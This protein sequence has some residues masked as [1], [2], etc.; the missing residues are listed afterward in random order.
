MVDLQGLLRKALLLLKLCGGFVSD[1]VSAASGSGTHQRKTSGSTSVSHRC[2]L[3]QPLLRT[4]RAHLPYQGVFVHLLSRARSEPLFASPAP[5]A[6]PG[7]ARGLTT[8]KSGACPRDI[9]PAKAPGSCGPDGRAFARKLTPGQ[10]ASASALPQSIRSLLGRTHRPMPVAGKLPEHSPA[11]SPGRRIVPRGLAMRH[12]M[13]LAHQPATRLDAPHRPELHTC[14]TLVRPWAHAGAPLS[15]TRQKK[16]N[17][18]R[19]TTSSTTSRTTMSIKP[20]VFL[21]P[22]LAGERC[23]SIRCVEVFHG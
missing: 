14:P 5:T 20:C 9:A 15:R 23:V 3:G 13:P 2:R 7:T 21:L 8:H 6:L 11:S 4:R 18:H 12:S 1:V 10:P 17:S 16:I 22:T 19:Y